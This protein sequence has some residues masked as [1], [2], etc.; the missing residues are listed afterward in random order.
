MFDGNLIDVTMCDPRIDELLKKVLLL[1]RRHPVV[2]LVFLFVEQV[3]YTI[4]LLRLSHNSELNRHD[5]VLN[6]HNSVPNKPH[7]P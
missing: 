6:N 2:G 4:V 7:Y 5:S 3:Q 1:L